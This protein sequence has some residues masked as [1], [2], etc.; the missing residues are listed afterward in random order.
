ML[1]YEKSSS[2]EQFVLV[3]R[4][5]S[6]LT[7]VLSGGEFDN[8]YS[9]QL[10]YERCLWELFNH[11]NMNNNITLGVVPN[12][13]IDVNCKIAYS[14]NTSLPRNVY[15]T[16]PFVVSSGEYNEENLVSA[17]DNQVYTR[18]NDVR[19]FLTKTVTYPLGVDS[20]AQT[21]TAIQI[22]DSGNLIGSDYKN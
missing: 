20:T 8:I 18:H 21:I 1:R 13:L 5:P 3:G 6:A 14:Q 4:N 22:Y 12:Y 9:D 19:Y 2:T 16:Q 11:S 17:Y 10:A 15:N 7:L